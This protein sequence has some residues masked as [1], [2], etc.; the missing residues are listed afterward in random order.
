M[1]SVSDKQAG[2]INDH[3][4][5]AKKEGVTGHHIISADWMQGY[6]ADCIA[7]R[8]QVERHDGIG[9]F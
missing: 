2:F 4:V 7:Y 9:F 6:T 5:S 1:G 8:E 3:P